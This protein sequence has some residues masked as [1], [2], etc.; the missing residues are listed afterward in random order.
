MNAYL[1]RLGHGVVALAIVISGAV[2]LALVVIACLVAAACRG[3]VRGVQA[4]L[5]FADRSSLFHAPRGARSL[6]RALPYV[7][8]GDRPGSPHVARPHAVAPRPAPAAAVAAELV[9]G[10]AR[11]V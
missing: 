4:G 7:W 5:L 10:E 8:V 11:F 3:G 1:T 9:E 2:V 6:N